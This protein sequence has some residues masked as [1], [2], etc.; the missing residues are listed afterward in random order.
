MRLALTC[1]LAYSAVCAFA[2]SADA[3]VVGS[4]KYDIASFRV[5]IDPKVRA[6]AEQK[7]GKVKVR[8][9]IES[10]MQ[11]LKKSVAPMVVS[12]KKDHT[13][14]I[15]APSLQKPLT[16]KWSLKGNVLAVTMN[17]LRKA[18]DMKLLPGGKRIRTTFA[19]PGF[20]TGYADLVR[21]KP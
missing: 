16:G 15:T 21:Q 19:Q 18:P 9:Q 6:D 17:E 3:K 11:G 13:V 4:W 14:K 12:F 5:Q 1:L 20:G 8:E 10:F 7:Q 2:E